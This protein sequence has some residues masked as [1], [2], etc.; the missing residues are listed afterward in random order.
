MTR[1]TDGAPTMPNVKSQRNCGVRLQPL[2]ELTNLAG[3]SL[4]FGE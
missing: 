4:N 1:F 2:V 3:K